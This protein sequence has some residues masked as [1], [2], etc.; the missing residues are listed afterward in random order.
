[1]FST[2]LLLIFTSV[3]LD[4]L[5]IGIFNE[6]YS[7]SFF[8]NLELTRYSSRSSL[9]YLPVE[10]LPL[11]ILVGFVTFTKREQYSTV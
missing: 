4:T 9:V 6:C 3:C 1:M 7:L 8:Q 2:Q 10:P 11:L 5:E